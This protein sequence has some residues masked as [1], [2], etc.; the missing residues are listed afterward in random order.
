MED[1]AALAFDVRKA[2]LQLPHADLADHS[3]APHRAYLAPSCSGRACRGIN[4]IL[5]EGPSPDGVRPSSLRYRYK[6]QGSTVPSEPR[7]R[8]SS[9]S[10][11]TTFLDLNHLPPIIEIRHGRLF[12]NRWSRFSV[13]HTMHIFFFRIVKRKKRKALKRNALRIHHVLPLDRTQNVEIWTF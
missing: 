9:T 1:L 5:V 3:L 11:R 4:P 12:S 8:V 2:V 13:S 10:G 7:N 6:G